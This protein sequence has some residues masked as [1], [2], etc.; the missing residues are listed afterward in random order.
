[1]NEIQ[2]EKINFYFDYMALCLLFVHLIK[3]GFFL[4]LL[5]RNFHQLFSFSVSLWQIK[6]KKK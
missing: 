1:M 4:A 5:F 3:I 6:Q 2:P